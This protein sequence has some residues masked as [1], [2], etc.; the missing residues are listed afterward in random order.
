M[1][2]PPSTLSHSD[3]PVYKLIST[4]S[5]H[6]EQVG[7][8]TDTSCPICLEEFQETDDDLV[9][10]PGCNHVL[11]AECQTAYEERSHA[12]FC[13]LCN[14]RWADGA[15]AC[16][17]RWERDHSVRVVPRAGV[18]ETTVIEVLNAK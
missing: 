11:H 14:K 16:K 1:F 5:G 7:H 6:P 17:V 15:S 13:V 2:P 10:S 4:S 18:S 8:T 3:L 12:R 9:K